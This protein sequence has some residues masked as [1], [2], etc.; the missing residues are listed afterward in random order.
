MPHHK[1][2]RPDIGDG[3]LHYTGIIGLGTVWPRKKDPAEC[4]MDGSWGAVK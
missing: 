2:G 3:L 4:Q 1:T